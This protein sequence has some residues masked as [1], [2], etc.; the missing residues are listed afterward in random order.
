[1]DHVEQRIILKFLFMK[2]LRYKAA[3]NELSSV[4]GGQVYS[5]SQ[6]KRWI[7]RFKDGD[8]SCEDEDRSGRPFS[9]LSDAIR[10][11][12]E[13]FPF[14]SAKVLAKYFSTSLPTIS[15]IL[16]THLG[17]R[18]F[19][20]RWVPHELTDDQKLS[21]IQISAELL[22]SLRNDEF[23]GFCHIATGDES[24]FSYRYESTH[25]YAKSREGVPPRTRTT[26]GTKRAMVTIFFT[27]AKLLVLDMLPR[28]QKFN[29]DH[30]LAAI[31]PHL[32]SENSNARR[33]VDK[34]EL[35]VHMDN[36]MCHNGRKIREYFARKNMT[37]LPHPAY[38]PD[39]SP[40]DFWFFGYA[41]E[42]M[43]DR[44]VTDEDDLEDKLTEVWE[45]VTQD[46]LRSVFHE[47]MGRLEWVM[48]HGGEYYV[49]PH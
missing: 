22:T 20:R 28:D 31:A 13:K 39:L 21:R 26:I 9:D 45:G 48:G 7:R 24:W 33:R 30:F 43:K 6:V 10:L 17:L 36:S 27:G 1:M 8:L 37:R 49:N 47:W 35:L 40:C 25:C 41:K 42:R 2:G 18:K 16:T 15:R 5:L 3:H 12:L 19:S 44:V 11:H 34:K 14:T 38:S 32:S 23:G 46:V 4:L 29:Q